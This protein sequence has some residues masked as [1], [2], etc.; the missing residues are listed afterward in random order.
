MQCL[1]GSHQGPSAEA[2]WIAYMI[3]H[4]LLANVGL[5]NNMNRQLSI[6]DQ[7]HLCPIMTTQW[8]MPDGWDAWTMEKVHWQY[9]NYCILVKYSQNNRRLACTA[10][11]ACTLQASSNDKLLMLHKILQMLSVEERTGKLWG[12]AF[13]ILSLLQYYWLWEFYSIS[14]SIPGL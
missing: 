14:S 10:Y 13:V 3:N 8:S 11:I 4:I 9:E 2:K 6:S 1:L 7:L 12:H 5:T